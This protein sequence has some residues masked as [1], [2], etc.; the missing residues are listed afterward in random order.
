MK[1]VALVLSGVQ[2]V[3]KLFYN[4]YFIGPIADLVSAFLAGFVTFTSGSFAAPGHELSKRPEKMLKLYVFDGCPFC[5]KVMDTVSVLGL[6]VL[7]Y[8]CPRVTLKQYGDV[9]GS[10]FR[11]EAI[12]IGGKA[13][14]PLLID[15][16]FPQSVI[17]ESETII[18]HLW[19]YYGD[20]AQPP[21]GY[22]L[23]RKM[24]ITGF[25]RSIFRPLNEQGMLRI[26]SKAPKEPLI[27]WGYEG[28]PFVMR[29]KE[30]M[31]SLELPYVYKTAP[32]LAKRKRLEFYELH[33]DMISDPRKALG[34]IQ[35][36]LLIDPN[37]NNIKMLESG[38]IMKYLNDTYKVGN[39]PKESMLD[40]STK[41]ATAGHATM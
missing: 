17:Y 31:C 8:P 5:R 40:Y 13:Q 7:V 4:L 22:K 27:L 21:L 29:V 18:E 20:K 28:S 19:K 24:P 32:K 38:S 30:L 1:P 9:T 41:G 26:P 3:Y 12:K 10:R 2:F 14:F 34:L 15:E 37:N 23:F 33:A 11:G 25:I 36:P 35:V 16:N 6:D 39:A